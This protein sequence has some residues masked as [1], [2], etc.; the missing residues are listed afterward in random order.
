MTLGESE[1]G[2]PWWGLQAGQAERDETE[3][4]ALL[5]KREGVLGQAARWGPRGTGDRPCSM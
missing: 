2:Q 5:A 4:W 1:T 3:S